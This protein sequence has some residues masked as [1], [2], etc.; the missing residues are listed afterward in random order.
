[1]TWIGVFLVPVSLLAPVTTVMFFADANHNDLID[2]ADTTTTLEFN[3]GDFLYVRVDGNG[4]S[5]NDP[6]ITWSCNNQSIVS[7]TSKY[8]L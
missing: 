2:N 1:M 8:I 5:A 3:V 7:G 6:T 4:R